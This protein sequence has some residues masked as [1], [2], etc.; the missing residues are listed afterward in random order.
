MSIISPDERVYYYECSYGKYRLTLFIPHSELIQLT[1]ENKINKQ[2]LN[3]FPDG[4]DLRVGETDYRDFNETYDY[5]PETDPQV[6]EKIFYT[7]LSSTK[8]WKQFR[9][10]GLIPAKEIDQK[11]PQRL[12]APKKTKS[13][14]IPSTRK[15]SDKKI[16]QTDKKELQR[17]RRARKTQQKKQNQLENLLIKAKPK[18]IDPTKTIQNQKF[19]IKYTKGES[20]E[21]IFSRIQHKR[22]PKP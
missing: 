12:L 15:I 3:D 8:N 20:I 5:R 10:S 18:K 7:F 22:K 14:E 17:H 11:T 6:A 13:L 16:L 2:V 19:S 9:G 4:V 1:K 21:K